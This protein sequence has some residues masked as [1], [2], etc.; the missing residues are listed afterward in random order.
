MMKDAKVRRVVTRES[1]NWFFHLYFGH[2]IEYETAPFQHEIIRLTEDDS[3]RIVAITAFRGSAKSTLI[4]LSYVLWSMLGRQQ[5]KFVIILGRTQAQANQYL[6]NLKDEI[7][8]NELLRNDL[9]P[10][11]EQADEWKANSIVLP[12]HGVRISAASMES[13]IRGVRHAQHRPDLIICDD[14]EDI[15]SVQTK[16]HREKTYQWITGEVIPAG[17]RK[18]RFIFIGNLLHADCLLKR[19]E[20][21]IVGG[22]VLKAVYREYPLVDDDGICAWEGKYPSP[23]TIEEEHRLVGNETTWH[24]E[25]LL[26][27]VPDDGQVIYPEWIQTYDELPNEKCRMVGIGIDLAIS[28][29]EKADRTAM[30]AAR[31]YGYGE[32]MRIY[33]LPQ[34]VN[35]QL[36]PYD[37]LQCAQRLA[38]VVG[39]GRYVRIFVEDV[40]YQGSLVDLLNAAGYFASGFPVRG[41]DKRARLM[42]ASQPVQ[43]G[44]VFFPEKGAEALIEQLVGFGT[45]RYD[46]LADAFSMLI[47]ELMGEKGATVKVRMLTFR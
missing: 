14:L 20:R 33:I 26:R 43:E 37:T 18:T 1:H 7:M 28:Q 4:T 35:T 8:R 11:E 9:G 6:K 27:I 45:E 41:Q 16:E 24:R 2:Y 21:D 46:D 30:V 10:F 15:S 5:K 40:G 44:L 25:F 38:D 23:E 32:K 29:R 42:I 3:K 13:S 36:T 12:R 22:L 17:N 19:I 34:I 31:V 47:I 39:Q